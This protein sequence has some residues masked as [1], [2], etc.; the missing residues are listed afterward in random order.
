MK[1]NI[2][3]ILLII[4]LVIILFIILKIDVRFFISNIIESFFR[5]VIEEQRY[6]LLLEGFISTTIISII[7][8]ILGTMLGIL[9]YCIRKSKFRT[10]RKIGGFYVKVM[11]GVP[12]TVLLLTAYYVI[13]GR[14]NIEP[15]LVAI[16]TFSI[17]FSAYVSEIFKGAMDSINISQIHSAYALGFNKFQTIKYI[18]LPQALTYTIPV[19]KNEVVS[20]VK[21]TSIA[22]YISIMDLTKASDIIR[23]RTYEAFFP[24]IITAIIYFILCYFISKILDLLYKKVN[25]RNYARGD[26]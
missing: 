23:N 1:R 3:K 24:L 21:L 12:I 6:K 7:S 13:F 5:T 19:Y 4:L 15:V 25:P 26:K 16:I 18:I 20:L 22:G 9:I 2:L 17:Y 14:I 10:L 8:I 11:Q